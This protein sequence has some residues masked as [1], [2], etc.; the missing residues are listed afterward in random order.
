MADIALDA[1][2]LIGLLDSSDIHNTRA[3]SVYARIRE[4]G[5][6]PLTLDFVVQEAVSVLCRRS[7]ERKRNAPDLPRVL[8]EVRGWFEQGQVAFMQREIENLYPG[9]LDVIGQSGGKLNFNDAA[10]VVL[11]QQGIIGDVATFD[12]TLASQPD[13]RT[14]G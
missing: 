14:I 1:N 12:T 7:C 8:D 5:D 3:E 2:I 13:F 10:L 4:S 6:A 11:Q 9:I